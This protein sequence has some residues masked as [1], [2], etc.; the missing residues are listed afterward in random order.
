MPRTEKLC[1]HCGE[2]QAVLFQRHDKE[3]GTTM[4]SFHRFLMRGGLRKEKEYLERSQVQLL[5]W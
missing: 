1:S 2:D 3:T 5:I 4:V